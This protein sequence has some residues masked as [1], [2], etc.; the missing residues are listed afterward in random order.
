[1]NYPF[2]TIELPYNFSSLEPQI[3]SESL[4]YHYKL[5]SEK[6]VEE[7]N[8]ILAKFPSMQRFNLEELIVYVEKIDSPLKNRLL[9]AA[10]GV[11]N[12]QLFFNS[13]DSTHFSP[14]K[15]KLSYAICHDFGSFLTFKESFIKQALLIVGS[16]NIWLVDNN[17]RLEIISTINQDT[18]LSHSL[19][20]LFVVDL[21]EHTYYLQFKY[22]RSEYLNNIFMILNWKN[23]E[24]RYNSIHR[25]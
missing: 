24:K 16:G 18:P 8:T 1:M 9:T 17:G 5:Y 15:E 12:H 6:Y 2:K 22:N 14:P 19:T 10:G 25:I 23:I 7:L 4:L 13:L 11:Y 3:S 20:P 21:W